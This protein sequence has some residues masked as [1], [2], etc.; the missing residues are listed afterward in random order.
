VSNKSITN[1]QNVT[2]AKGITENEARIPRTVAPGRVNTGET[3]GAGAKP[4]G[5]AI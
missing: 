1:F 3:L 4:A 5:V 2:G